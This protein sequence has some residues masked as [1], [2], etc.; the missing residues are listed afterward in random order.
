MLWCGYIGYTG[1]ESTSQSF[2]S[3]DFFEGAFSS[4]H[5]G[6]FEGFL[7]LQGFSVKVPG[8]VPYALPL[9]RYTA[10]LAS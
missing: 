9:Y 3:S 10:C 7:D 4:G 8:K 2:W 1:R 5:F 6:S